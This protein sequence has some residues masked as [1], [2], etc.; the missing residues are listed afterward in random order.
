LVT[1]I[2]APALPANA[3]KRVKQIDARTVVEAGIAA[4]VVDVLMAVYAGI[5][6]ITDASATATP[7][8]TAA[9]GA[10]A[11]AARLSVVQSTE[12]RIVRD[13][14][15]AISALPLCRAV[16]IIVGL[17]VE[18]WCR[19]AAWIWAAMIANDLAL[20]A[21]E[22]HGAHALISVHQ[23]ATFAAVLARLGRTL[24]DVNVAVLAGVAGSTATMVIVHQID[25]KRAVLTLADAV[26]DILRAILAGK[27]TPTS[28]PAKR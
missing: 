17:R 24:V 2:P 20:V 5:T 21:G 4:A 7:A 12:L 25:A 27:T 26:V 18:T 23:I 6:R 14:F 11:S 1:K 8:L 22:A 19:I 3:L 9:R 10:L 13:Q 15:R 16:T 28:A